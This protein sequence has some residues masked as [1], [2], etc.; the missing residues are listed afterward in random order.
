MSYA[1]DRAALDTFGAAIMRG[2]AVMS[3]AERAA[4]RA[5][6]AAGTLGV[7]QAARMRALDK[8]ATSRE[9]VA[10]V[11]G[12]GMSRAEFEKPPITT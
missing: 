7:E 12:Y 2:H 4:H 10:Y 5:G 11:I 1:A 3:D 8:L 6:W 9:R